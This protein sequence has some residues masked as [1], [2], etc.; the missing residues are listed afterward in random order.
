VFAL[1]ASVLLVLRG[2]LG[3]M[4]ESDLVWTDRLLNHPYVFGVLAA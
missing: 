4:V 1:V 3:V 2:C